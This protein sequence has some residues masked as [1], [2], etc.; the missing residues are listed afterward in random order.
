MIFLLF[1]RY[2]YGWERHSRQG[3]RYGVARAQVSQN[4]PELLD[5][6]GRANA[7]S[8]AKVAPGAL[9]QNP[10]GGGVRLPLGV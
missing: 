1:K 8:F 7:K 5:P 2:F 4:I 6:L 10:L 9:L 3:F